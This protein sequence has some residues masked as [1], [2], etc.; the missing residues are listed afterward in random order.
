MSL[1]H[2]FVKDSRPSLWWMFLGTTARSLKSREVKYVQVPVL[3]EVQPT[4]F[5]SEVSR[6]RPAPALIA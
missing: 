3:I 2:Q 1:T 5:D 4:A 6:A